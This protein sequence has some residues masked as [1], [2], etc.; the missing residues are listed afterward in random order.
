MSDENHHHGK[1]EC[2]LTEVSGKHGN[3]YDLPGIVDLILFF[4]S[5]QEICRSSEMADFNT[6]GAARTDKCPCP[7]DFDRNFKLA[8]K[9]SRIVLKAP[10]NH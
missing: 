2:C 7:A 9:T 4:N 10:S 3:I 8:L 6:C 5:F 1:N